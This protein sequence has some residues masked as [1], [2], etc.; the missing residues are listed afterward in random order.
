VSKMVM[1]RIALLLGLALLAFVGMRLNAA[2]ATPS[3]TLNVGSVGPRDLSSEEQTQKAI[4]RDYDKAW[5]TLNQA[6]S[7]NA[8]GALG[9]IWVGIAKD[10]LLAQINDQKSSGVTTKYIDHG[11]KLDALF[12]SAEGSA[13]EFRDTAQVETQVLDGSKVVANDTATVHYLVVMTPTADHW[14]VRIFQP[15]Q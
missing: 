7:D 12:Y 10:K 13:L 2:N 8:P 5:K 11:H 6:L 9:D 14:Q 1:S 3:V 15:V 4:V